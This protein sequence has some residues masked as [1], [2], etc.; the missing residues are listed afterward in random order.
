[1]KIIIDIDVTNPKEVVR[2]HKGELVKMLAGVL[3]SKDIKK[4]KVERAVCQEIV[5]VLEE[6]LPKGLKEELVEAN[7]KFSIEPSEPLYI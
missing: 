1:M 4:A 7:I 5:K 6:E 2:A 3:L